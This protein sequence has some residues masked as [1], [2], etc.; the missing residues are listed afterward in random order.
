MTQ[1]ELMGELLGEVKAL[2]AEMKA[3]RRAVLTRDEASDYLGISPRTLHSLVSEGKIKRVSLSEGR[4]GFRREELDRYAIEHE[5]AHE[6]VAESNGKR[7]YASAM[8]K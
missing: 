2:R 3:A 1:D 6:D 5:A 8:G 7:I 4:F